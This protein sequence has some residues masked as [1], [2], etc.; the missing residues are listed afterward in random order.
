M[1]IIP[2]F[3]N[4]DLSVI[5]IAFKKRPFLIDA[6]TSVISQDFDS[7]T[8]EIILI[9]NF[10]DKLE[11]LPTMLK[12]IDVFDDISIGTKIIRAAENSNGKYIAFL[13]DD[14][15]F[16]PGKLKSI[17]RVLDSN[18]ETVYIN[19][20]FIRV[21]GDKLLNEM[22]F[23]HVQ[24]NPNLL[25]FNINT[26]DYASYFKLKP[27]FNLSSITIKREVVLNNR[28]IIEGKTHVVDTL[29]FA[30]SLKTGSKMIKLRLPFTG[31]RIHDDNLSLKSSYTIDPNLSKWI[32][33]MNNVVSSSRDIYN[34][35]E[36]SQIKKIF[37]FN[38]FT[39]RIILSL[40]SDSKRSEFF[41][42]FKGLIK[43]FMFCQL[44][45]RKD[46]FLYCIL[47]MVFP[48]MVHNYYISRNYSKH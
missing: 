11:F 6:I 31:Y 36:K 45:Y 26:M 42:D 9:K 37:G 17:L 19:N 3:V 38:Y 23:P 13:E 12:V 33:Y 29:L 14:D 40:L 34:I 2:W 35:F 28:Q 32:H 46:S 44:K 21:Y 24:S 5:I 43:N 47:S 16:L 39:S 15:I 7:R 4:Y 41:Y 20:D 1:F 27:D 22:E 18:P 10:S 8:V 25:T 30:L 48:K